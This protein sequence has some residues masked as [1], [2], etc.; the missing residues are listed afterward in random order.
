MDMDTIA[1][2]VLIAAALAIAWL[3]IDTFSRGPHR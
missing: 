1:L 2:A 3:G